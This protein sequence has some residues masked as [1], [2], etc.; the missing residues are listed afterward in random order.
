[1]IE[2]EIIQ[3]RCEG[4]D[5]QNKYISYPV[6]FVLCFYK[7]VECFVPLLDAVHRKIKDLLQD[8]T[9]RRI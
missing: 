4:S 1:M 7:S 9:D 8:I 6:H 5:G 2:L 3:V